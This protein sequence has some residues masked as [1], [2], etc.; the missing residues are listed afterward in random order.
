MAVLSPVAPAH[1]GHGSGDPS[2]TTEH[3]PAALYHSCVLLVGS[4]CLGCILA[5][6]GLLL[7]GPSNCHLSSTT[8][9]ARWHSL[10]YLRYHRQIPRRFRGRHVDQPLLYFCEEWTS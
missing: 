1:G 9:P 8:S 10:L 5:V 3:A 4:H 2:S 7:Y 6:L